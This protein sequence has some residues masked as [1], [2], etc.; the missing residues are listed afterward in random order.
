MAAAEGVI[1]EEYDETV[2][3]V[4]RFPVPDDWPRM[5]TVDFGF[6]NPFVCQF[7]AL[8]PDGR[9]ILYREI[10][11]SRRTVDQHAQ[12]ILDQV[13]V[14]EGGKRVRTEPRPVAVVCDHDAEG[15]AVLERDLGL[16]TTSA[17]KPV[18]TGLQ[19]VKGRLRTAGDG[20]PRLVFMRDVL[21]E[22]DKVLDEAKK[23]LCTVD[24]ITSYV[25]AMP[26]QNALSKAESEEPLKVDDHGMD[27]MRYGVAE[28]DLVGQATVG[29]PARAPGSRPSPSS[30]PSSAAARYGRSM[31]G[32]A[33]SP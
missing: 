32:G 28:L 10:Y 23:P 27:G 25:W 33:A 13:T 15:R 5:W 6:T 11:M 16:T 29:S 8:D 21:V 4:D 12:D 20:R 24:E 14:T 31:G 26:R 18:K 1:Y 7:W 2:H 19:A 17:H 22:R 9:M 30:G 3:L